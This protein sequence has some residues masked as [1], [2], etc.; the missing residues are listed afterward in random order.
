MDPSKKYL[1]NKVI[2]LVSISTRDRTIFTRLNSTDIFCPT[3]FYNMKD[4]KSLFETDKTANL[5]NKNDWSKLSVKINEINNSKDFLKFLNDKSIFLPKSKVNLLLSSFSK[6]KKT[7]V[8]Y[9]RSKF[10]I[11][12]K[13]LAN[14][15]TMSTARE[16]DSG[17]WCLYLARYFL[18]G[19]LS[20][21]E[22]IKAP[23]M[24]KQVNIDL[25]NASLKSRESEMLINEKLIVYLIKQ[26]KKNASLLKQWNEITNITDAV[27]F[28]NENFSFDLKIP[29]NETEFLNEDMPDVQKRTSK[30][31]I[32]E[33]TFILGFFQPHGGKLKQ[34]LEY[35]IDTGV[36]V[37]NDEKVI[38]IL[39]SEELVLSKDSNWIQISPLNLSQLFALNLSIKSNTII[40]G[41]PGTGKSE[42]IANIIAN[43]M[44][45][46]KT[47]LMVS[48]KKAALDVLLDRLGPLKDFGMFFQDTKVTKD[49]VNFYN[50]IKK[51]SDIYY[52]HDEMDT[53]FSYSEN[54]SR[55]LISEK[56]KLN[57]AFIIAR[58]MKEWKIGD[59][60]FNN[61]L[62]IKHSILNENILSVIKKYNLQNLS[63]LDF[64]S[65]ISLGKFLME[66][67]LLNQRDIEDTLNNMRAAFNRFE[68]ELS[69]MNV[70]WNSLTKFDL[71]RL[72]IIEIKKIEK[73]QPEILALFQEYPDLKAMFQKN[74]FAYEELEKY[75]FELEKECEQLGINPEMLTRIMKNNMGWKILDAIKSVGLMDKKYVISNWYLTNQLETDNVNKVK[76]ANWKSIMQIIE[77][78]SKSFSN[79]DNFF[80]YLMNRETLHPLNVFFFIKGFHFEKHLT[81]FIEN[82][83]LKLDHILPMVVSE[84]QITYEKTQYATKVFQYEDAFINEK[85]Q[86]LIDR[87]NAINEQIYH[88]NEIDWKIIMKETYHKLI[89]S[90]KRKIDQS[91]NIED[92]T[93]IFRISNLKRFPKIKS[94]MKRYFDSLLEIFPIWISRPEDVSDIIECEPKIFNYGIFDEASQMFL[95]RAYPI[96]YRTN[97]KVVAGDDK[98]LKPSSFFSNRYNEEES[99]DDDEEES[100]E[101]LEVYRVSY[102]DLD[103]LLL[104]AIV[105]NWNEILLNNHYRSVSQDLIEFS[106][107][108][109]YD[110]KLNVASFNKNFDSQPFDVINV[111]GFFVN[112]T[113]KEEA[114]TVLELISENLSKYRKILVITF[115]ESQSEL[116]TSKI[117]SSKNKEMIAKMRAAKLIITNLENVQGNEGDFVILSVAY[118][119]PSPDRKMRN[120]FGP[121]NMD[122]G[123]NRLNVAVTR[124]K[125]KM[126]VVKSFRAEDM[127]VSA[128][129]VNAQCFR[130]FILHC[131]NIADKKHVEKKW[132]TFD[133]SFEKELNTSLSQFIL[134]RDGFTILPKYKIGTKRIDI[135]IYDKYAKKVALAL[136][137]HQWNHETNEILEG[138]DRQSFI[139]NR[140]Y[141]VYN[142]FET[143]WR[144]N[145]NKIIEDIT[146][147]IKSYQKTTI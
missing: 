54:I 92:I 122:G 91:V 80:V 98:Q 138:F 51:L 117:L 121:I 130:D 134:E 142:V 41:P 3:V 78:V 40:H 133:T 11:V 67:D 70:F 108:N 110:N 87:Y 124:A 97:I 106:N 82:N 30:K 58:R 146:N 71:T 84:N 131:D 112:R 115:N 137:L 44:M 113:N 9:L 101:V 111:D 49:K 139:K 43:I 147:Q 68:V 37:F 143:D 100:E 12:D 2:N 119:K 4:I 114:M 64:F 34:D 90:W 96:L 144:K 99:E 53:D 88:A 118:G 26:E 33:N 69:D 45:N 75:Y 61:Y 35:I 85:T 66:R 15:D 141:A 21:G 28:L 103:S 24:F 77:K 135:A 27:N 31:L 132:L 86:F 104:R 105:S 23:I 17:E 57:E 20:N 81:D 1:K 39:N 10:E 7:I 19:C 95:E 72:S 79:F 140:G 42:T 5:S 76:V 50:A 120:A 93:E 83:W 25:S 63:K 107:K 59:F 36:D 29:E 6:N 48:E 127:S 14:L 16:A 89:I 94:F 55:L 38:E 60:D 32:L 47:A 13:K 74:I 56:R 109:I 102:S 18:T 136:E 73:S 62:E 125:K 116:I 8:E 145:K 128:T 22:V 52:E 129:N 65:I 123:K 126:V 46:D